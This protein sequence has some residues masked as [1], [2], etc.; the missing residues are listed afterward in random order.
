[1]RID[2]PA[3][4]GS[5]LH[6]VGAAEI[7]TLLPQTQCRQCG[8]NGC[9][10]YADAI[11]TGRAR[12]NQCPPGG[13]DLAREL[14]ALLGVEFEP[15]DPAFGVHKPPAVAVID[16]Q[17]CIGCTLCIKACPVD[18]IVGAPHLM[19]GVLAAECTGCELCLPPCPVDCIRMQETGVMLSREA[20]RSAAA[21]ARLR[22][23]A[24]SRRLQRL[25]AE[26]ASQLAARTQSAA[27]RKKRET[28]ARAIERARARLEKGCR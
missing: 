27:D 18:A 5:H 16:E 23:E 19:H 4:S 13:D 25:R 26:R 1:M 10:P 28:V 3:E 22:Y 2:V 15:L 21:K 17:A 8:Y 24:R 14:A 11:A 9:R 12:I 20:R 6:R 7:E